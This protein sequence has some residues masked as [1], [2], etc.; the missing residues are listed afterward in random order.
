M[1]RGIVTTLRRRARQLS[2]SRP[3]PRSPIPAR[4]WA[5]FGWRSATNPP[6]WRSR[7]HGP[8][9][10]VSSTA[11]FASTTPTTTPSLRH[12]RPL[13]PPERPAT[14]HVPERSA[15]RGPT[16]GLCLAWARDL[17]GGT[18][19]ELTALAATSPVGSRGL[20]FTPWLAGLR[21]PQDDRHARG[22]WHNLSIQTTRADLVRS[23]LEGVAFNSRWLLEHVDRFV[24]R[25]ID[26]LRFVGG[27]ALS[28][29]WSQIHADVMGRSIEQ[30]A[31]PMVAQLRGAALTVALTLGVVR[32]DAVPD[33]VPVARTFVPQPGPRAAYDQVY[34]EFRVLYAQQRRMFR[35]LNG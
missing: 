20:L 7:G 22:G 14:G 8:G 12:P 23:I 9:S 19:D 17:W 30:V 31:D 32:R 21:S 24:G 34:R 2:L 29:L 13:C 27:G 18:Y 35:R 33:L 5:C 11:R 1:R 3:L 28:P 15:L 4:E 25:R 6:P 26:P 10:Q 16:A